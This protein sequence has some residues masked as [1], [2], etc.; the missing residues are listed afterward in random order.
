MRK[1]G[2]YLLAN[3]MRAIII[4]LV[5]VILP[6]ISLAGGFIA[7]ILV[8]FITLCRG[9]KIGFWVLAGVAIPILGVSFW[10]QTLIFDFI[11]LPAFLTWILAGVLRKTSSWRLVLE[12]MAA[13][14][15]LTIL[16][17]HGVISD[18]TSWWMEILNHYST[19][20][21]SLMSK[22]PS[23]EQMQSILTKLAPMS[24][25]VFSVVLLTV[26]FC[27]L[28]IARWW[29]ASLFK[30]GALSKEFNEIR[31][32]PLLAIVCALTILFRFF[33]WDLAVDFLPIIILPFAVEGLSLFHHWLK[34]SKSVL[35]ILM[36]VY[37]LLIF[38]P[39]L[40]VIILGLVGYV[41]CWYDLRQRFL[42]T[43][44]S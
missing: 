42:K 3:P 23:E 27:E 15:L 6:V 26:V 5:C 10:T 34:Y 14:G 29:Q 32:S 8:G 37:L 35:Y 36:I 31:N 43:K 16:I 20:I 1:L 25:G 30:P 38:L 33:D 28:I 12:L 17:F 18:V 21:N 4:A 19:F 13:A 24:T 11:L 41:D 40:M 2:Q 44:V 22:A 9:Y 39:F 7:A